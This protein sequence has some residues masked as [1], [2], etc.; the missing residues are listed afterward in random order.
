MLSCWCKWLNSNTVVV[1]SG[2]RQYDKLKLQLSLNLTFLPNDFLI[3]FLY[4]L[5][6]CMPYFYLLMNSASNN[7]NIMHFFLTLYLALNTIPLL[8]LKTSS[9]IHQ[10][11]IY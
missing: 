6:N 8:T 11:K 9:I 5:L 2:F 3:Q 4:T 1:F 7:T 10:V